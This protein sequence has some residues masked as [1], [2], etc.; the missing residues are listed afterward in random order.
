VWGELKP[1]LTQ[2]ALID[3]ALNYCDW[4]VANGLLAIRAH[5]V[6]CDPRLLAVEAL[7]EVK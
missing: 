2:A 4:V 1:S 7:L 3:R 5:V 6:V